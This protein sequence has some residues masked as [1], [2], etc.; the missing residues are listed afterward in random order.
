MDGSGYTATSPEVARAGLTVVQLDQQGKLLK[1]V[2]TA[3]PRG[4]RQSAATAERL[5]LRLTP[6]TMF[7]HTGSDLFG[8]ADCGGMV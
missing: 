6:L 8:K 2:A 5:S 1:G 4:L 7:A 3:A